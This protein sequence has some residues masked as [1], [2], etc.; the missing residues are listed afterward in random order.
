[1]V[2][3]RF[4]DRNLPELVYLFNQLINLFHS[5][6]LNM[7]FKQTCYIL[8]IFLTFRYRYWK[9]IHHI[10][11][12]FTGTR[13]LDSH[14]GSKLTGTRWLGGWLERVSKRQDPGKFPDISDWAQKLFENFNTLRKIS[15]TRQ[16][17]VQTH[18]ASPS[19]SVHTLIGAVVMMYR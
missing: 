17:A 19:C 6:R 3:T 16:K 9:F 15:A 4:P 8:K 11:F 1:L 5:L 18:F 7:H 12:L 2:F 14:S 10:L 13:I